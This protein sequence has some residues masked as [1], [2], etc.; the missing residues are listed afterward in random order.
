[1]IASLV[2]IGSL[3]FNVVQ[4]LGTR[5][6]QKHELHSA[7]AFFAFA[8]DHTILQIYAP[9]SNN[10][11]PA[12]QPALD[13]AVGSELG[14]RLQQ[15]AKEASTSTQ[16]GLRS[17]PVASF[18]V[19]HNDGKGAVRNLNAFSLDLASG[20]E[21]LLLKA[22]VL[23]PNDWVLFPLDFRPPGN[24]AIEPKIPAKV[25]LRYEGRTFEVTEGERITWLHDRFVRAQ[26]STR[27]RF[28]FATL[29]WA[30]LII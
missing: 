4:Y 14:R 26:I 24:D 7:M 12:N 3:S 21:S 20:R 16:G 10:A 28:D 15:Y 1:V 8:N 23:L 30:L 18:L 17:K 22:A 25:I 5:S 13:V 2:A 11:P 27:E 9:R 19:V 29:N 6:A